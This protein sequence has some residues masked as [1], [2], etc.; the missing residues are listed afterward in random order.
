MALRNVKHFDSQGV[1]YTDNLG[2]QNPNLDFTS[3]YRAWAGPE[4]DQGLSPSNVN[5]VGISSIKRG[6]Y[7]FNQVATLD[8]TQLI[9][10]QSDEFD[11]KSD[12]PDMQP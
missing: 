7:Q 2:G 10:T 1:F 6:K 12:Y 5:P 8:T 3:T 4:V 11:V 9:G